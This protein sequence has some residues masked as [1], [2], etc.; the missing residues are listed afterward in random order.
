MSNEPALVDTNVLVYS[1]FKDAPQHEASRELVHRAGSKDASL[2]VAAQTMAEFY[3]IVT[4]PRRVTNPRSCLE[5]ISAIESF[6]SMPGL[7]LVQQPVD[8]VRRWCELLRQRPVTG[9][10]VFDLQL[11]ATMTAS[12]ISRI[13]TF[14]SDDFI[15]FP[16]IQVLVP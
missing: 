11:V 5:A 4:N 13:F 15:P 3:S 12:G 6:L 16:S 9:G 10:D 14:N 2:F 7:T 1:L 8:L